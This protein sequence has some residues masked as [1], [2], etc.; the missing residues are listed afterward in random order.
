MHAIDKKTVIAALHARLAAT[1]D[2]LTASQKAVQSGAVHPESRQEHPKDTRATEAGYLARGLAERV[3]KLRDEV[4]A[5]ALMPARD[6]SAADMACP[7]ALVTIADDDGNETL[8]LLA[9]GGGGETITACGCEILVLTPQSPLGAALAGQRQ[10][11]AVEVELPSG[12]LRA[13]LV[14]IA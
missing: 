12:K 1:L 13:E 3:E 6:F 9:P 4:R 5:V 10:G 8:V 14:R 11:N 2:T 7:G